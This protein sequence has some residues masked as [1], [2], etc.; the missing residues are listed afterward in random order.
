MLDVD[1]VLEKLDTLALGV[2]PGDRVCVAMECL[3]TR[4]V[5]V[6]VRS[7][8]RLLIRLAPGLFLDAPAHCVEGA[9]S[10]L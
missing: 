10:V 4:G 6:G 7:S 9:G 5:V 8:G 3:E 1:A 2:A